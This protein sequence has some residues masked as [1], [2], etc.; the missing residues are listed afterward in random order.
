MAKRDAVKEEL[1]RLADIAKGPATEAGAATL[2]KAVA[3]ANPLLVAKAA[4]SATRMELRDLLPDLVASF[5]RFLDKSWEEDK[6]CIAKTALAEAL[7]S[8]GYPK[9]QPF[10]RGVRYFQVEPGYGGS[11]DTAARL[12]SV[13]ASALVRTGRR[14]DILFELTT[15]LMDPETEPRRVAAQNLAHAVP[16]EASELLLRLKVMV[17]DKS[18]DVLEDCFSGLLQL[19][20]QR[21]FDLVAGYLSDS[22]PEIVQAAAI[23]LAQSQARQRALDVLIRRFEEQY[24]PEYQDLFLTAIAL[25]R[26]PAAIDY[27]VNVIAKGKPRL[28]ET[29]VRAMYIYR[30]DDSVRERVRAAVVARG[31]PVLMR[32]FEVSFRR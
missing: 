1:S 10:L 3:G 6:G 23:A 15:L 14:E 22:E 12:R 16:C 32:E 13:C 21:S 25:A 11:T 31:S 30:S 28:A 18:A 2:R 24:S 17:G 27:L 19:S 20:P 5:D 29:A 26:V 8:L 4:Q 7:D 9:D